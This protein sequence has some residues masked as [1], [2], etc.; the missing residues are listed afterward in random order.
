MDTDNFTVYVEREVIYINN[1]KDAETN[2]QQKT[3]FEI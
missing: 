1:T 3:N 2:I